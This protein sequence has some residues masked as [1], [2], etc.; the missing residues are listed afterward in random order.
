MII[1]RTAFLQDGTKIQQE[2]WSN[3]YYF[4]ALNSTVAVYPIYPMSKDIEK[5][6][7]LTSGKKF[8]LEFNF[9]TTTQANNCFDSLIN[10][11][12]TIRDFVKNND[13]ELIR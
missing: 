12:K 1:I 3:D 8:R 7:H 5:N 2:N 10:G 6:K 13:L 4:E 9:D 11:S